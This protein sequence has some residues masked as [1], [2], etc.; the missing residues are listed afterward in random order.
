M[1]RRMS[2]GT[3]LVGKEYQD[4]YENYYSN[5]HGTL[6]K[7][8][9][10]AV[11]TVNAMIRTLGVRAPRLLLDVGAGDGN[12]LAELN[13]RE[14]GQE[15]YALDISASG[16]DAIKSKQLRLLREAQLFDGY[17]IPYPDKH[18]DLAIAAHV[19]EHVEHER[20]FLREIKR[21]SRCVYVEVP[22]E[23]G[24][25]INRSIVSGRKFG[26]INFYTAE[27]L[28][29]LLESSGLRVVGC[30]TVPSSLEYEQYL[31]GR[32]KGRIKNFV[33]KAAL[34]AAPRLAPWLMVYNG[35][36]YCECD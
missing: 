10:S 35:C 4:L 11:Q 27:T 29:N 9:I 16:V 2:H 21:V 31:S 12:V 32:L 23:H 13:K 34:A 1:N 14:F 8:Q 26:H 7:R 20:L 33:R 6:L 17:A 3:N 25:R 24:I 22:L 36:A 5:P 30:R 28:K 19:L 15:L 18:F